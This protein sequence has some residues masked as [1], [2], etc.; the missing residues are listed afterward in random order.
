MRKIDESKIFALR[1]A[2]NKLRVMCDELCDVRPE[3]YKIN[4]AEWNED[5]ENITDQIAAKQTLLF[6]GPFSSGKSSFINALL[7]E[8]VLPTSNR[9][10][11]SVV[12]ELRFVDGGGNRGFAVRK[13]NEQTE[14]ECDFNELLKMIDGPTGAIGESAAYHH[15]ELYYDVSETESSCLKSLCRAGVTIV[16]CPGFGSPYYSNEDVVEEYLAK[17]SHTFWINPVDRMGGIGDYKR[18]SEIKKKT[19]KLIPIMSKSDLIKSESHKEEICDDYVGSIGSIF[20]SKE[21]IFCSAIKYK[22]G[23]EILKKSKKESLSDEEQEKVDTLF[24]ESGI[25]NVFAALIDSIGEKEIAESKVI[26]AYHDLTDLVSRLSRSADRELKY[27]R[28]ELRAKGFEEERNS[29]LEEARELVANWIKSESERV[30]KQLDNEITET[31]M[32]YFEQCGKDFNS[33]YLQD[34]VMSVWGDKISK[35]SRS[36]SERIVGTYKERQRLDISSDDKDFELPSALKESQMMNDINDMRDIVFQ[37]I[38]ECGPK[39]AIEG[40]LGAVAIAGTVAIKGAGFWGAEVLAVAVGMVGG[41]LIGVAALA[42]IPVYTRYSKHKKEERLREIEK[43]LKKWLESLRMGP[44]I[45]SLLSKQN[46][47]LFEKLEKAQQKVAEEL[48]D[49]KNVCEKVKRSLVEMADSL[50]IQF[51]NVK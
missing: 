36:W 29:P 7:Q 44:S 10:C 49:K 23:V 46:E 27:W 19:T 33:Y 2:A 35:N 30:G 25:S 9:P 48:L 18:L 39:T 45:H 26:V 21:P 14:E 1:D 42:A 41:V 4:R 13:D 37:T 16:D 24:L 8:D 5:I 6:I 51:A 3:L 17:A 34:Q 43:K 22:E 50:K 15:I 11:T 28:D 32:N 12:T 20:R 40:G 31:V 47:A 38:G